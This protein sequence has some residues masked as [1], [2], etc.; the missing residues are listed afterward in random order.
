MTLETFIYFAVGLVLLIVGA[1][2]LVRGAS[3]LAGA[4]GVSPL[5]IGLTVVAFGTSA[6]ELAVSLSAATAGQSDLA[7]GNVIGSNIFNVLF[8]LGISAMITPLV[9]SVQLIRTDVP[10][11]VGST[12]LVLLMGIDGGITRADGLVLVALLAGY[13]VLLFYLSRRESKESEAQFAD[14]VDV[15]EPPRT[16]GKLLLQVVYILVGLGLLVLGSRWLVHGA[17]EMARAWNVDELVI[18]LTIIAAGTSLPEVATSIVAS[19]RGQRDIAVGNIVGSSIFNVFAILGITATVTPVLV[20]E[21][22]LWFD[23]PVMVAVAMFCLPIFFTRAKISR[24][25]GGIF[26][27]YYIAYTSYV[28]LDELQHE[29]LP[30]Y[31]SVL[32]YA[33]MPVTL[34]TVAVSLGNSLRSRR[35]AGPSP[36]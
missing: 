16:A 35:R 28:V 24:W 27:F 33:V 13:L 34:L 11:M 19:M 1:E 12:V 22:A 2:L 36:P 31:R 10:I 15:S 26:F 9:V 29:V 8:I 21:A 5:V 32:L 3:R 25:E 17:A 20:S 14:V 7:L 4:I 23:V 18:G 30:T 6:P